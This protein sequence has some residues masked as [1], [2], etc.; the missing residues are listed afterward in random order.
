FF[1]SSSQYTLEAMRKHGFYKGFLM[2][3]DRLQR[4][5]NQDWVYRK[6]VDGRGVEIKLDPVR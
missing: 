6:G 5:N 1:P 4:E 2:G 3:C